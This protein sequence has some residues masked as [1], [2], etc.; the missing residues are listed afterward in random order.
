[1]VGIGGGEGDFIADHTTLPAVFRNTDTD[2]RFH[3][4]CQ[5]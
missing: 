5:N 3:R 4:F 2:E 1:M